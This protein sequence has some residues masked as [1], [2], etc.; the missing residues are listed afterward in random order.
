[1]TC[2]KDTAPV[3]MVTKLFFPC[4]LFFQCFSWERSN[5]KTV[6]AFLL[7]FL[8]IVSTHPAKVSPDHRFQDI[9]VS[10]DRDCPAVHI[11]IHHGRLKW[12]YVSGHTLFDSG[13][14]FKTIHKGIFTSKIRM[15]GLVHDER[16]RQFPISG[17]TANG[18]LGGILIDTAAYAVPYQAF[19]IRNKIFNMILPPLP[20][21]Q[22]KPVCTLPAR[23][24]FAVGTI[25]VHPNSSVYIRKSKT[26]LAGRTAVL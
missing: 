1:M 24:Q 9:S 21:G 6:Q 15:S 5:W 3:T 10:P 2:C 11:Q 14:K 20:A 12:R 8:R 4:H 16:Q 13:C 17:F 18:K 25:T 22:R 19:I 7:N 26:G 23:F